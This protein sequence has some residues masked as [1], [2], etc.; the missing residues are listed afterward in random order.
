[1]LALANILKRVLAT[2]LI[3]CMFIGPETDTSLL[4]TGMIKFCIKIEMKT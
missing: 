4:K 1:M 2:K 3:F